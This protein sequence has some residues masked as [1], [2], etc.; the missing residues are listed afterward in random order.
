MTSRIIYN[1][2]VQVDRSFVE[3]WKNYMLSK[4]IPEIM[5]TGCFMAYSFNKVMVDDPSGATYALQLTLPDQIHFERYQA[6]HMT[7]LQ[8]DHKAFAGDKYAAFRTLLSVVK[9]GSQQL[10]TS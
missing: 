10:T 3:D 5:E 2:T 9:S 1:I 4:H 7:A 6:E 8:A